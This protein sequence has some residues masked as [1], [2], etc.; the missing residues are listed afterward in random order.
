MITSI[1]LSHYRCFESL[2]INDCRRMNVIVGDNG[3]G[4]TSILEAIFLTL[5]GNL[6]V[7]MRYRGQRGLGGAFKGAPRAIEEAIWRD[8]FHKLE[9]D[10]PV[11][12]VLNGAGTEA[13]SLRISKTSQQSIFPIG[14]ESNG[15]PTI[16]GPLVFTW[17]DSLGKSHEVSP[18]F[19]PSGLQMGSTGED[20]L[21]FFYLAAGQQIDPIENAQRFTDMRN[22]KRDKQF[23][24]ALLSEYPFIDEMSIEVIGGSAC[25]CATMKDR[26]TRLPL[27][28]VSG[29]INRAVSLLLTMASRPKSVIIVDEIEGGLYHK[30]MG[31]LWRAISNFARRY[32]SQLFVTTHSE[33]WLT[34]LVESTEENLDDVSL[35]RTE[36]ATGSYIVRQFEGETL[37]AGI[38]YGEEV[39]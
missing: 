21:D 35:W 19:N 6:E 27:A 36:H 15:A 9:W 11:S 4:K 14:S 8:Y 30:H 29:G 25:L 32:D 37:R 12:I 13:R 38:E 17:T 18:E 1:G 23:I 20:L 31:G 22:L 26:N 24:E 2:L 28:T 39:R 34:A 7:T 10:K 16:V 33:E 3:S 5:S